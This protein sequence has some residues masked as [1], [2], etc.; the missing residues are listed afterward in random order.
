MLQGDIDSAG[1]QTPHRT[2]T[3]RSLGECGA[4]AGAVTQA[5]YPRSPPR[6]T[7]LAHLTFHGLG[8]LAQ[9]H[10][11]EVQGGDHGPNVADVGVF[12]LLCSQSRAG[13][14]GQGAKPWQRARS[15]GRVW[16]LPRHHSRSSGSPAWSGWEKIRTRAVSHVRGSMPCQG[17]FLSFT[18]VPLNP[19]PAQ[20]FF[21]PL[22]P[23][24][25]RGEL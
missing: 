22:Y 18:N 20:L 17:L 3:L 19:F 12:Q 8:P 11:Q 23:F 14:S 7:R 13:E 2:A 24:C 9:F 25:Y 15:H 6:G 16:N 5:S 21:L 4:R 1:P 10:L